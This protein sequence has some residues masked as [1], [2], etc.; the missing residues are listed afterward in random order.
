LFDVAK[1]QPDMIAQLLQVYLLQNKERWIHWINRLIQLN[2][3]NYI[4][5][6]IPYSDPKL[7]S[8]VYTQVF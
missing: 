3:V 1:N 2:K 4:V 7:P 5:D 6:V 8:K